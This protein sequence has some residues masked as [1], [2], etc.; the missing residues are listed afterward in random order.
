ME[1]IREVFQ[2]AKQAA[3]AILFFDEIDAMVPTRGSGSSDSHATERVISQFLTEMDGVEELTGVLVLGAT[4]RADI[5]DPALL[6]PGRF[7]LVL[8]VPP[9]DREGRAKIFEI[10]LRNQPLARD[11]RVADLAASADGFTGADVQA[12]CNRAALEALRDAIAA[13]G[14]PA[15][16]LVTRAH[17]ERALESVRAASTASV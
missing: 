5:L 13:P 10:G 17:L 2:K 4:N 11:V 12:V 9:P 7:D 3:P 6:R 1:P 8:E 14:K 16:I 15:K